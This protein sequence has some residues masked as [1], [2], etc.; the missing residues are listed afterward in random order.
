M[1]GRYDIGYELNHVRRYRLQFGERTVIAG[2]NL[3]ND[4]RMHFIYRAHTH[5]TA[6][7]LRRSRWKRLCREN[8]NFTQQINL[9]FTITYSDRVVKPLNKKKADD[10]KRLSERHDYNQCQVLTG[11]TNSKMNSIR[12]SIFK[13][14][15][16]SKNNMM[17][18]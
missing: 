13:K 3:A 18:E 4:M 5:S 9:N 2:F 12:K 14:I 15:D 8:Q 11:I 1:N 6:L 17:L 16:E 7:A 10:V